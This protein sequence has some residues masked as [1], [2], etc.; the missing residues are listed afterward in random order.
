M[1]GRVTLPGSPSLRGGGAERGGAAQITGR[2]SSL[3]LCLLFCPPKSFLKPRKTWSTFLSQYLKS[4]NIHQAPVMWQAAWLVP[5]RERRGST[6]D[7]PAE[8]ADMEPP[9]QNGSDGSTWG[10]GSIMASPGGPE[11]R[12]D[13]RG[14]KMSLPMG[15]D[16]ND[17]GPCFSPCPG[18]SHPQRPEPP[19]TSQEAFLSWFPKDYALVSEPSG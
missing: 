8:R 2:Q 10:E 7:G 1:K 6:T 3:G 17:S 12:P 11:K 18:A 4:S 19:R 13:K 15:Q 9:L 5:G 14:R 16:G